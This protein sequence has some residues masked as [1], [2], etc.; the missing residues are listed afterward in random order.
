MADLN[1]FWVA[2]ATTEQNKTITLGLF[3][4]E[5]TSSALDHLAADLNASDPYQ[6]RVMVHPECT[7]QI[8]CHIQTLL[9]VL[10][11]HGQVIENLDVLN[12]LDNLLLVSGSKKFVQDIL[13]ENK[14]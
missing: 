1:S 5:Q 2:K 13:N 10:K 8:E 12:P 4:Q 9:A 7:A 3:E 14:K 11:A 6:E